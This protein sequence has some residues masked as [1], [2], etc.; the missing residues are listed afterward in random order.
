VSDLE[1]FVF[2]EEFWIVEFGVLSDGE[3]AFPVEPVSLRVKPN[4][5]PKAI[6]L[7]V[8]AFLP[9]PVPLA[10]LPLAFWKSFA[11]F[12]ANADFANSV[13]ISQVSSSLQPFHAFTKS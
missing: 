6:A 13:S 2:E 5:K 7:K 8:A 4:A 3:S 10:R 1:I 11:K 9:E 12:V